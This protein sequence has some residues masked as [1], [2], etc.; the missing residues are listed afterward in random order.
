MKRKL[1]VPAFKSAAMVTLISLMIS[2]CA[3][4]VK[5]RKPP[6]PKETIIIKP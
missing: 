6:P 5:D 1:L 3:V 2:S 4:T